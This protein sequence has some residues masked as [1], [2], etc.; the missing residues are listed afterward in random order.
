MPSNSTTLLPAAL[1]TL[2]TF[3]VDSVAFDGAAAVGQHDGIA[4]A[5]QQAAEMLLHPALAK[6]DLGL[7][8]E[9]K[10]V[11]GSHPPDRPVSLKEALFKRS[12]TLGF[13]GS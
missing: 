2:I 5:F 11:H 6:I 3:V 1:K 9:N 12:Q 7:V 10:I 13:T 4:V 8:F